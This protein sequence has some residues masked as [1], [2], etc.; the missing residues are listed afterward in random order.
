MSLQIRFLGEPAGPRLETAFTQQYA[1]MAKAIQKGGRDTAAAI[2]A[3]GRADIASGGNFGGRWTS[4]FHATVGAP[5]SPT[6]LRISVF[7]DVPYFSIFEFGG[8]IKG[9]PLLW[10]PF[11]WTGIK[12]PSSQYQGNLVRVDRK[13]GAP[14]LIDTDDKQPKYFGIAQV[15]EKKRFH[16]REIIAA[17]LNNF[18]QRYASAMSAS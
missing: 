8:V 11:S 3:R 15:T 6:N 2:E 10:I 7:S 1:R 14:L 9:K 5:T 4:G 17:E 18:R 16:I 12:T 13:D